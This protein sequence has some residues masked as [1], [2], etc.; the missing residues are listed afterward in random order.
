VEVY[1]K[2]FSRSRGKIIFFKK[3]E[4]SKMGDVER[5]FGKG[6]DPIEGP[7][8]FAH[9]EV[10]FYDKDFVSFGTH[11]EMKR[12][13]TKAP[14]I[15]SRAASSLAPIH[16]ANCRTRLVIQIFWNILHVMTFSGMFP[17]LIKKLL[18]CFSTDGEVTFHTYILTIE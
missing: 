14:G 13:D 4:F 18:L 9:D 7:M 17:C 5:P 11:A 16:I 3:N 6:Q 15:C 2:A 10:R 8:G 12:R 1:C